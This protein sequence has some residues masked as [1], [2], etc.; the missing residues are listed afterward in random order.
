MA[1][2]S[3]AVGQPASAVVCPLYS[4][5]GVS[6]GGGE[7]GKPDVHRPPVVARRSEREADCPAQG[8]PGQP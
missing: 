5:P 8:P 3:G 6:A 1:G 2:S 7:P 4:G